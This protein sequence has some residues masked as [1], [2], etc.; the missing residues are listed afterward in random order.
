MFCFSTFLCLDLRS[1]EKFQSRSHASWPSSCHGVFTTKNK[2]QWRHLESRDYLNFSTTF[3]NLDMPNCT[4][5]KQ[6]QRAD[7]SSKAASI[8]L[9]IPPPL[10]PLTPWCR[11]NSIDLNVKKTKEML[12]DFW[13]ARTVIPDLFIDGVKVE[14][15]TE[16]K[17]QA[18]VLGNKLNFNKN[19]ASQLSKLS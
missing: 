14:R 3:R 8:Y 2:Q 9:T 17:Y 7:L 5:F 1:L 15:V 10:P 18:T 12:T 4:T 19:T 11:E 16:Y 13:N 6:R